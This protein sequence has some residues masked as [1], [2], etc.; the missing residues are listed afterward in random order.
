MTSY[1]TVKLLKY[2]N[3]NYMA[4]YFLFGFSLSGF[5]FLLFS[6]TTLLQLGVCTFKRLCLSCLNCHIRIIEVEVV[7]LRRLF[8]S[9]LKFA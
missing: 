6:L 4:N 8:I 2:G 5:Y 3:V 1:V 9:Y 7:M